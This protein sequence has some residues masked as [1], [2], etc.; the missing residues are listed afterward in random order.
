MAGNGGENTHGAKLHQLVEITFAFQEP[1]M[2]G[3]ARL[4]YITISVGTFY[5]V[6]ITFLHFWN[7]F[8]NI[9]AQKTVDI[10]YEILVK[11]GQSFEAGD[12]F[13][14]F[15]LQCMGRNICSASGMTFP[16]AAPCHLVV[17]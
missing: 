7:I 9:P 17:L 16:W 14:K 2:E 13:E 6:N 5:I 3:P 15:L 8:T 12:E 10:M 1:L 11:S 4:A